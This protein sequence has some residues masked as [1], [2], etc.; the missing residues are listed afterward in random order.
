MEKS[1]RRCIG[2]DYV[3]SLSTVMLLVFFYRGYKVKYVSVFT[4]EPWQG[5][6]FDEESKKILESAK[7]D[8]RELHWGDTHH[9]A[10]SETNGDLDGEYLTIW[11]SRIMW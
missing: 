8:G 5:Y 3:Y 7:V 2:V 6:G 9:P 4:P 11:M 10:I 1:F